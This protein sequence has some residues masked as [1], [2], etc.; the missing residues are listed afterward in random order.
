MTELQ[1]IAAYINT[2]T[3]GCIASVM[4][5][6]VIVQVPGIQSLPGNKVAR[7][8][9]TEIIRTMKRAIKLV[10]SME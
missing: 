7:F 6:N 4:Y 8:Y 2:S 9:S 3:T 5:D 10:S 1:K